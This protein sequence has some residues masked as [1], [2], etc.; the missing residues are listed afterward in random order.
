MKVRAPDSA[1]ETFDYVIVGGGSAGSAIAARLSESGRHRVLLLEAGTDDRWIWLRVP[2]GAGRV[3]LSERSLWRFYTE[4]EPHM[5]RRRMYWPRGRVLGGSSTING[6]LWVR[7]EPA[8]YDAWRDAGCP[9][10]G[11]EDV[12]PFLKRCETYIGGDPAL[13]GTDGAINV[14]QFEPDELGSAF[15]RACIEAG[16][17]ATADYNGA[18]YEGVGILQTNTRRGL[19]HGGREA[20]LDPAR[21]RETL[22]VRTGARAHRIRVDNGR[23]VGVEYG[24][25][26]QRR[27]VRARQEVIVSAGA[28]QSPHLLELSGIGDRER[29]AAV[30]H[31]SGRPPTRRRREL[32]RPPAHPHLLRMHAPDHAE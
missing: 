27:F 11:Y 26:T 24:E 28:V 13:R 4:P 1:G 17:P 15:H 18:Q 2:L 32:S 9:G 10:W 8:E 31:R 16:I 6:M 23:A 20:Y 3:L 19:R 29:L 25:G 7:G 12:L 21:G 30:R 14:V 22:A 5:G